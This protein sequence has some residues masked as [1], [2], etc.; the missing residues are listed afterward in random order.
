MNSPIIVTV[1]G[2]SGAGKGTVCALLAEAMGFHLLDSGALYRLTAL[3]SIS[4]GVDVSDELGVC[5]I[6]E[7]L[8]VAFI[9]RHAQPTL[10]KLAGDDVTAAIRSEKVGMKASVVAA[11]PSVR[12]VL[13]DR[14][15]QFAQLPGLVADGRDM[16]TVVFPRAQVKMFLTASAEERASRRYLQLEEAGATPNLEVILKDIQARD[17]R[18]FNRATAPLK[19]AEDAQILDSTNMSIAEVV[20]VLTQK[21]QQLC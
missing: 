14:Q 10:V 16:G 2:P 9:P 15:R 19:P 17:E 11:Y 5:A 21:V 8:N 12:K 1:D 13:L 4:Q 3:S 7:A 6:A 20:D 18:D